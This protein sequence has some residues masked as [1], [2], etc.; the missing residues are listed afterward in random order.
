MIDKLYIPY[1]E[2]RTY[3]LDSFYFFMGSILF[4]IFLFLLVP[5]IL[6]GATLPLMVKI[7]QNDKDKIGISI[8]YIF[9]A[10]TLGGVFGSF[11]SGFI[12]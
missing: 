8:G 12:F 2:L 10:N 3:F 11:A 6:M 1:L 9:S 7:L 4:L 5:T